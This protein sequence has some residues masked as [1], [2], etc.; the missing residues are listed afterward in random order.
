M[1]PAPRIKDTTKRYPKPRFERLLSYLVMCDSC[2][3]AANSDED[4]LLVQCLT[5][6]IETTYD[7]E[8]GAEIGYDLVMQAGNKTMVIHE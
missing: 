5:P 6:A 2:G 4:E 3:G 8:S 1:P 7:T